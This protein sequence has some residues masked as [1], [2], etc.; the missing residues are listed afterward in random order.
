[1]TQIVQNIGVSIQA[2]YDADCSEYEYPFRPTMTQIVQNIRVPIQADYDA[3]C[4]E[5]ISTHS[6]RL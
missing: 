6:G 2:D 5:Y 3:D 1:M 4:S